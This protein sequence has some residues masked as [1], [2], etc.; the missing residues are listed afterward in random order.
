M[1]VLHNRVSN[2]ELK[3]RMLAETEPRTTVSFYKYFTVDEP[4]AFRDRLYTQFEQLK[5][6][7]RIY[8]AAEG[9]NAQISVPNSQFDMFK[10]V[11]F[12]AHPALDNVRLN[13]AL[14]DDGKSF[15]V[16]RMKVR[17]RIVADGIDDPTF[18]PANVGQYLKAEQVNAMADDPNTLFVDMRNHYEYEVG[19]FANALEVPS[20]TFR[21]QLPMAVDMLRHEQDKNIVMYCTGGIRCEKASAYMLHHG[22]KHVY[23]VEGG[24]IEYARQA[25]A[26]GLP[27]KFIGKNFVFDERMGERI[28]DDVIAHCHQC[29]AP[30][31]AH[32]NCRNEGCH[33][34]FIQCPACAEKYEGCCSVNCQE[35]RR[36]PLAEQ[37]AR[38]SGRE[39]GM[40]VFNKSKGLLKSTLHIPAPVGKEGAK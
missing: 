17:E 26:Q 4:K 7:G 32:T 16:L 39:N 30:C 33:L 28:S 8:I 27:L 25:K 6:F 22:F 35:E 11:L 21:E 31:D 23:H 15:W 3:A 12:G 20:D 1:P 24:I 36:L 34:L 9:I 5:V 37:R 2:E 38:R 19:H 40:K 10:T 18:N 13:I 14:D 29:G